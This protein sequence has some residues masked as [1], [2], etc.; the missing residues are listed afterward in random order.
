MIASPALRA[1]SLEQE[2]SMKSPME[3]GRHI[4]TELMGAVLCGGS[5]A[6]EEEDRVV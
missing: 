6:M 3:T 4:V 1:W 2:K 5:N